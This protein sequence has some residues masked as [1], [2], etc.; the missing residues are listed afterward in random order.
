MVECIGLENRQGCKSFQGSNPCLSAILEV[1]SRQ[2]SRQHWKRHLLKHTLTVI[3]RS[4]GRWKNWSWKTTESLRTPLFA[5]VLN[6]NIVDNIVDNI[7]YQI[8]WTPDL[9]II[10]IK[11]LFLSQECLQILNLLRYEGHDIGWYLFRF[12]VVNWKGQRW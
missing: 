12:T 3:Y 8:L 1:I 9:T 2:H 10:L 5:W 4:Y 6:K 7:Y 11:R